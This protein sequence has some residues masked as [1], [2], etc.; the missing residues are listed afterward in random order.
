LKVSGTFNGQLGTPVE[1]V[2]HLRSGTF[3]PQ[4]GTP[5]SSR[6]YFG[7]LQDSFDGALGPALLIAVTT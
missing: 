4:L 2:W 3:N 5:A 6:V 7:L 1:G